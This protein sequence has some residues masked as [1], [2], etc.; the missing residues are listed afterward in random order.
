LAE[1]TDDQLA[2]F[3]LE[4]SFDTTITFSIDTTFWLRVDTTVVPELDPIT[5]T[6]VVKP[7]TI[8]IEGQTVQVPTFELGIDLPEVTLEPQYLLIEGKTYEIHPDINMDDS[9]K[10][11]VIVPS[12]ETAEIVKTVYPEVEAIIIS[13]EVNPIKIDMSRP[14][15]FTMD[16]DVKIWVTE[17]VDMRNAVIELYNQ[18]QQPIA[19]VNDLIGQINDFL[20][21]VNVALDE[22]NKV[23]ELGQQ[24]VDMKENIKDTIYYYIEKVSD[25]ILP[26]LTPGRYLQPIM[27]ARGTND[28]MRLSS[29]KR[30]PSQ[31]RGTEINFIPTTINA[32]FLSPAYRKWVAVTDVYKANY[33]GVHAKGGDTECINVRKTANSSSANV[34]KVLIGNTYSVPV[35]LKPGYVYEISYQAMDY[36][37]IVRARKYY[38]K[39]Q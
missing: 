12:V 27:F 8:T 22:L 32:E 37:G 23:N 17:H 19:N 33:R 38:V 10:V 34:N 28:F 1:L 39:A 21:N 29:S 13:P 16:R 15:T 35:T 24:I 14:F 7:I 18:M 26:Y 11:A 3:N 36:S 4:M 6:P 9:I 31:V 5:V 30:H 2:K 20:A 25:K